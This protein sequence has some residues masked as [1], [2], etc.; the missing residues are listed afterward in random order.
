MVN[1]KLKN[2][3]AIRNP[4][5]A[6]RNWYSGVR[7]AVL[8]ASGFI[9]RWVA[10]ALCASQ[11]NVSLI[12]RSREVA[13][14]I[15]SR[16]DIRGDVFEVDLRDREVVRKLFQNIRPSITFNLAGYGVDRSE[17]DEKAA[18]QINGHLV[19][20]IGE[21]ISEIRD[22]QWFGQDVVHVGSALEYGAIRGNLSEDSI[23]NPTTLYGKSKLAGTHLLTHCCKTFEMKGVTA[24]LFTVYGP[25]EHRG[26]LLPSLLEAARTGESLPLTA[27]EQKRDF[28]YVEDVAEG[29]LRLGL[30]TAKPGEIVNLTTGKLTSV[31]SFAET[32]AEILQIPHE[33][34][35]FGMIPTRSEEMNHSEVALERLQRLIAWIPPTGIVEGIRRTLDFETLHGDGRFLNDE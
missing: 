1:D 22:Q 32:A 6:I 25:G 9:G 16:Y 34:L 17:R 8:G 4:Q 29:L 27:G 21:V 24:R 20:T 7:V 5:S 35:K 26:R 31:R 3:S 13:E 14:E 15:F 10:R 23:P 30:T 33:R 12:V 19:K 2:T 11:A 28:T 18:Y